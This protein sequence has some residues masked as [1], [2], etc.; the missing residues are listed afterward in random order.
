MATEPFDFRSADGHH[1]SGRLDLPDGR[2]RAYALFAHCF[3][4]TKQSIAAVR[5]ARA[6]TQRGIGVLRFDF[7]GLGDSE[8]DFADSTFSG[9]VRDVVAAAAEMAAKGMAP[10]LLMG[11]SLGGAAVL[12]AAGDIGS[13]AAVAVIGAPFDVKHVTLQF[14][15]RLPELMEKGEAEVDLGGRPFNMRRSFIDDLE[16]HDQKSRIADLRRALLVLHSPVDQTVGAENAGAIFQAAKH[17][18][19]FVSLDNADHLLTKPSDAAY[20]ADVIAA[21]SSRYLGADLDWAEEMPEMNVVVEETGG[22]KYQVAVKTGHA[23]FIADEPKDVGGL[24]SGPTPHQ[25]VAAGLGACTTMT[26]R[27]YAERKG[28]PVA[29]I[30]TEVEHVNEKGATP[31]DLFARSITI[32]G[33][34]DAEMRQRMIEIAE[35]CPVHKTLTA[36]ARITTREAGRG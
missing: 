20:A 31:P 19:S 6:L 25:L 30:R 28:W 27:M 16:R 10:R 3:T 8:G 14:G 33:D 15:D 1:L 5:I 24:G 21:W 29:H 7:T 36:G 34:L 4:C 22:G 26:L 2:P 18:K 12:A 23:R 13:V 35:K 32:S 11:H 9:N 17:P